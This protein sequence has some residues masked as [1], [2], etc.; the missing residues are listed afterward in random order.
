MVDEHVIVVL[1][2]SANWHGSW[3]ITPHSRNPQ[4]PLRHTV[5]AIRLNREPRDNAVQHSTLWH[6][7]MTRAKRQRQ[8]SSEEWDILNDTQYVGLTLR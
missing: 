1:D 6:E 5:E 4:V 3:F 7:P 8:R 2:L